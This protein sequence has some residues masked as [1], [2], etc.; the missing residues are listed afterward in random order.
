MTPQDI[1]QIGALID[2]KIS[3]QTEV[4]EEKMFN[5]KSEIINAVDAMAKEVVEER[6]F[7]EITTH[8]IVEN[9]E[10]TDRLEMKVFGMV[11]D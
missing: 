7:R 2:S 4:L 6:D 5:C 11:G 8:Q 9:R 10:R 3:K 1:Q